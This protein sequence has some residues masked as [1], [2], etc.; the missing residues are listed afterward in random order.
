M[1]VVAS[2]W[3]FPLHFF[4]KISEQKVPP[5]WSAEL[6][7][8]SHR[9]PSFAAKEKK[10]TLAELGYSRRHLYDRILYDKLATVAEIEASGWRYILEPNTVGDWGN[11]NQWLEKNDYRQ[12]DKFLFTH[13]DNFILTDEMFLDV[14]PREDWLIL[15]N[16]DGNSQRRLRQWLGLPKPF[17]IRG[18]FEF[19]AREMLDIL[20]GKFDLSETTLRREGQVFSGGSFKELS[21]WNTTVFP[22]TNLL[23]EKNL[24]GRV[25]ALSRYYRMSV[26]CLEGERGYVHKTEASNTKEEER[27]LDRVEEHYSRQGRGVLDK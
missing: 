26:Y 18:S 7:C 22:L 15:A 14:L 12:Y 9:N 27:G 5:G 24:F 23:K 21:D 4:R 3:H 2:G 11:T 8:V 1:A 25:K 20:G 16:S 19:F 17:S 13:D 10:E 6:F